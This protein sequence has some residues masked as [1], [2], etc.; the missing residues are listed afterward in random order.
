[1]PPFCQHIRGSF[2]KDAG[3]E[4]ASELLLDFSGRKSL[5]W[6]LDTVLELT[7]NK[8]PEGHAEIANGASPCGIDQSLVHF[9]DNCIARRNTEWPSDIIFKVFLW[10][11][12]FTYKLT[13]FKKVLT[14][15]LLN[16]SITKL[17]SHQRCHELRFKSQKMFVKQLYT[18]FHLLKSHNAY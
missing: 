14:S 17:E 3:V 1:M 13:Q 2:E 10:L 18:Y 5:K 9:H 8:A 6:D 7:I 16:T 12:F 11:F 15:H 4:K